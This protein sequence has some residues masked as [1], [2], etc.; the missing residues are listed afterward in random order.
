ME[1]QILPG[2]TSLMP[3]PHVGRT[4]FMRRATPEEIRRHLSQ[5][6]DLYGNP[7]RPGT[8]YPDYDEVKRMKRQKDKSN[9]LEKG[10]YYIPEDGQDIQNHLEKGPYYPGQEKGPKGYWVLTDPPTFVPAKPVDPT[11]V[12]AEA[13]PFTEIRQGVSP[14][15]KARTFIPDG[16]IGPQGIQQ[17]L[18]PSN[19]KIR[20]IAEILRQSS[21]PKLLW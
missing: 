3:R 13:D 7:P 6:K 14:S 11:F 12:P 8:P 1:K 16:L 21:D 15:E 9:Y 2:G 10:P 17:E 4:G 5:P 19:E 18:S 20:R